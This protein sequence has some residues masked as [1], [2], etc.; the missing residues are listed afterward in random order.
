MGR[1]ADLLQEGV[2]PQNWQ[3]ALAQGSLASYLW[4]NG[5]SPAIK[6][7]YGDP[8][9][10]A[11]AVGSGM[12]EQI[13][14]EHMQSVVNSA[15]GIGTM[16]GERDMKPAF[17]DALNI[18]AVGGPV[19]AA[20]APRGSIAMGGGRLPGDFVP[21][22][23]GSINFGHVPAPATPLGTPV[24]I[25]MFEGLGASDVTPQGWVTP[26]QLIGRRYLA[27]HPRD[28]RR[29]DS[30]V[31]SG[32]PDEVAF[33]HS[34][35]SDPTAIYRQ[36]GGVLEVRTSGG[37]DNMAALSLFPSENGDFYTVGN[38]MSRSVDKK[39]PQGGGRELVWSKSPVPA[40]QAPLAPSE[41]AALGG[42]VQ[43][44]EQTL[45]PRADGSKPYQM[46]MDYAPQY[47]SAVEADLPMDTASRMARAE[48]MGMNVSGF[49]GTNA[50][51]SKFNTPVVWMSEAPGFANRY[52]VARGAEGANVIPVMGSSH[53]PFV[54]DRAER[55]Q[56]PSTILQTAFS[57]ARTMHPDSASFSNSVDKKEISRLMYEVNK[58]FPA[59]KGSPSAFEYWDNP[60]FVDYLSALGFDSIKVKEGGVPTVGIIGSNKV[61][62]RSAA[63][64]PSKADS[65]DI[66]AANGG[67]G[68][69][70]LALMGQQNQGN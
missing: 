66:L 42:S 12:L 50:D 37:R 4:N 53:S 58:A 27:D 7:V 10:T 15:Q 40:S 44:I 57:Q 49:H 14:P 70:A 28:R 47:R 19:G 60:A 23:T 55:T 11:K 16:D 21:S 25:R 38:A 20:T 2:Q 31:S 26:D 56:S 69:L 1:Y 43:T 29:A 61:R 3:E 9:G 51:I 36:N 30:M 64:D 17:M 46:Y 65:A 8:V 45:Y 24:P 52:A 63:F 18:G 62:A 39:Y 48:E 67:L 59:E 35:T 68:P 32:S 54:F 13:S 34:V 5:V 6:A 33:V 22:P 41:T